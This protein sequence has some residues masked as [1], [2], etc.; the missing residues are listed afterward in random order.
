MPHIPTWLRNVLFFSFMACLFVFAFSAGYWTRNWQVDAQAHT[1]DATP[2][3]SILR[4]VLNIVDE[5]FLG[6]PPSPQQREYG[7][8]RGLLQSYADPYTFFVEPQQT[9]LDNNNLQGTFGGIGTW[10]ELNQAGQV[11][12]KPYPDSPAQRAGILSGDVLLAVDGWQ[13]PNGSSL[14]TVIT[15][16]RGEVQ[17][18]V[19]LTV[20]TADQPAR[21]VAVT[22]EMFEIPSV[23]TE[24]L[25]QPAKV[26]YLDI[27]RFS[28]QTT[29]EVQQAIRDFEQQRVTA[30]I[31]DLRG[32][33]GGSFDA[34]V[35]VASLFLDDKVVVYQLKRG[36]QTP[37]A[38]RAPRNSGWSVTV[39]LVMW[40]DGGTASAS[41][42]LAGALR[43]NQRA[44]LIGGKTYGKGSVQ[45]LFTLNDNSSVHVTNARWLV[46]SM[47]KLDG[48]GLQPT[49]AIDPANQD[50]L[51]TASLPFLTLP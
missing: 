47:A 5:H 21:T 12:L 37:E 41:E 27:D 9:E 16:I 1:L 51:L 7:Q 44:T 35:E 15:N 38:F 30:L 26:G 11:L 2:S 23:R 36:N 14:D 45:L 33:G 18:V 49:V 24:V 22:R 28:G 25:T 43:D 20:Q 29:A 40:V 42:I 39:P 3:Q 46:P 32:N 13:V 31:I 34:G 50:A 48:I 19:Q 4:D 8:I 17:T 10:I 6:T